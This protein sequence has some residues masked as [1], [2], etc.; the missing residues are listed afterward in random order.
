MTVELRLSPTELVEYA[1]WINHVVKCKGFHTPCN[2]DDAD[3]MLAKL[4]LVVTEV[5]EAAEAVRN[6]DHQ[7]FCEELADVLI[8]VLDIFGAMN[9]SVTSCLDCKMQQNLEREYKHGKVC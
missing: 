2:I 5:G 3:G 1:G 4:M 6:G 7:N 9:E 8:R